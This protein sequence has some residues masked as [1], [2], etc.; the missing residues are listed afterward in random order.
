LSDPALVSVVVPCYNAAE[1]VAEAIGSVLAQSHRNLECLAVD[2][3][4]TDETLTL[5][6]KLA[7]QDDRVRVLRHEGG[8]NRGV[9]ASRNLALD[10]AAG[11]WIALLDADDAWLPEKLEVQLKAFEDAP[12]EVGLVF[13]DVWLCRDADPRRPMVEQSLERDP[14][15]ASLSTMFSAR[16]GTTAQI[17]HFEPADRFLNWVYSPTPLVKRER[18]DPDIRFVGPPRLSTQF[19]DY[20]MWLTLSLRCEFVAIGEPLA[21]YRVHADQFTSQFLREQSGVRLLEHE[22]EMLRVLLEDHAA[23]LPGADWEQR[24][25]NRFGELMLKRIAKVP[26]RRR[27][28]YE[29]F[30]LTQWFRLLALAH[31]HRL[32]AAVTGA[33]ASRWFRETSLRLRK[34]RPARYVRSV[35]PAPSR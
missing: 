22:E 16:P 1:T 5:L 24:V 10:H 32:V 14:K 26:D 23:L 31:R 21:V 30:P 3:G 34:S 12:A 18:F 4:S 35:L 29:R 33:L 13:A 27:R 25:W 9:A 17:M 8:A 19:E 7:A 11:A 28:P 20:L 15:L 2:D 6:E